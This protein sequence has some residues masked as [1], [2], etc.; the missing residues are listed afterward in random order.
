MRVLCLVCDGEYVEGS[1]TFEGKAAVCCVLV[2]P[3][4][5][6]QKF[7][8]IEI[9]NERERERGEERE[10]DNNIMCIPLRREPGPR[11][12]LSGSVIKVRGLGMFYAGGPRAWWQ[13]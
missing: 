3:G 2:R 10:D 11:V 13:R 5:L 8:R 6:G 7:V 12:R 1:W 9:C 4:R